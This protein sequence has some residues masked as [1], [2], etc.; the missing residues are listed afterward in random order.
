[1]SSFA[2]SYRGLSGEQESLASCMSML[3]QGQ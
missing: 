3:R 1:V 2:P